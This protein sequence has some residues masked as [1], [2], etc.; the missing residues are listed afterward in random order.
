MRSKRRRVSSSFTDSPSLQAYRFRGGFI[1]ES[2]CE[3]GRNISTAAAIWQAGARFRARLEPVMSTFDRR[4]FIKLA[5]LGGAVFASGLAGCASAGGERAADDE[6]Y[7]VQLSDTH[8][9]F[10]GAPNPDA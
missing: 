2:I 6:F 3:A 8:W 1:P 10:E 5:G 4:E 9:G 7:F